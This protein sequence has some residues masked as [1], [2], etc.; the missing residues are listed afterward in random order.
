MT[1]S[2]S[3]VALTPAWVRLN[4]CTPF[5]R[6]PNSRLAPITS[7]TLPM[8]EPVMDALTRSS[9]PARMAKIVMISSAALP[10]VA[11]SS[12][13]SRGPVW[14]ASSSV[15]CPRMPAIGTTASAEATNS[16]VS[17]T[18]KKLPIIAM[19]AKIKSRLRYFTVC[20]SLL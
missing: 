18:C 10:R 19:G 2:N 4:R 7:S 3:C 14:T 8:I 15:A 13:P 17:G 12:P 16:H 1:A 20:Y 9:R 11:F 6:P 5:L